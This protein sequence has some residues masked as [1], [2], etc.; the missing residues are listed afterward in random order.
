MQQPMTPQDIYY[1]DRRYNNGRLSPP[2][3]I[4][5]Q[6][7]YD[8][9]ARGYPRRDPYYDEIPQA[10]YYEAQPRSP[11]EKS[12]ERDEAATQH[13]RHVNMAV[14]PNSIPANGGHIPHIVP[15]PGTESRQSENTSNKSPTNDTDASLLNPKSAA[16]NGQ[17]P[18]PPSASASGFTLPPLRRAID[19]RGVPSNANNGASPLS[20][21]RTSPRVPSD[22]GLSADGNAK[23]EDARQLG[24]LGKRVSL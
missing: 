20:Y 8:P 17:S 4:Y 13:A 15:Q 3:Q 14:G 10:Q 11:L 1:D 18:A 16:T 19:D 22:S 5:A 12:R 21:G 9:Y 7:P 24:E 2:S 23:G 6:H